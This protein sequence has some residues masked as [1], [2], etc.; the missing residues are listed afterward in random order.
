MACLRASLAS[1]AFFRSSASMRLLAVGP[2]PSSALQVGQRFAKP[3]LPGLNSNS[4]EQTM[5]VLIGNIVETPQLLL[6]TP[7][8]PSQHP[9]Q[10]QFCSRRLSLAARRG[11]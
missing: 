6:R 1:A 5:Q 7:Y 9:T 3:G 2:A 4:S 8:G 10:V 11:T